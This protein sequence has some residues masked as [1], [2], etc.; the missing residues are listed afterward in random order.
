MTRFMAVA[1]ML[2]AQC[3]TTVQA[4]CHKTENGICD[5]HG[6]CDE[7]GICNCYD[8]HQGADCSQ[9]SCP[10]GRS[11]FDTPI[12]Q[13]NTAHKRSECSGQGH[14]DRATGLCKCKAG[15]NGM[16]CERQDCPNNCNNHGTCIS[17]A[18][19]GT[20]YDAFKF[21]RTAFYNDWDAELNY[22]CACDFQWEGYDCSQRRLPRGSN[23]LVRSG[24]TEVAT[25]YCHCP[26]PCNGTFVLQFRGF[27]SKPLS[28]QMNA[29]QL[30]SAFTDLASVSSN[31]AIYEK[32]P[33]A[34]NFTGAG[35]S[36]SDR[37]CSPKGT[38]TTFTFNEMLG[39]QY[40]IYLTHS[41]DTA[42]NFAPGQWVNNVTMH[43]ET[44][45][46]IWCTCGANCGGTFSIGY[47][48]IYTTELPWNSTNVTIRHALIGLENLAVDEVHVKNG[49][50]FPYGPGL[51]ND[52]ICA[53]DQTNRSMEITFKS[54]TGN[55]PIIDLVP[56]LLSN[57]MKAGKMDVTT[58]DGTGAWEI[59]NGHGIADMATATCAC[60]AG[61]HS[62]KLGTCNRPLFNTSAYTGMQRCPGTV[63]QTNIAIQYPLSGVVNRHLY[64]T[65]A[66]VNDSYA[67]KAL[68]VQKSHI[69]KGSNRTYHT[70]GA[71]RMDIDAATPYIAVQMKN[72]SNSSAAGCALDL[73]ARRFYYIDHEIKGIKFMSIDNITNVSTFVSGVSATLE[74][75]TLDLRAGRRHVYV[76][77]PGKIGTKD[78]DLLRYN[79]D[80]MLN[81][82]NYT[83]TIGQRYLQDPTGIALDLREEHIYWVDTGNSSKRDGKMYRTNLDGTGITLIC[84][85]FTDPRGIALDLTNSTAFVTDTG[86]YGMRRPA[87]VKLSMNYHLGGNYS[88]FQ[89]IVTKHTYAEETKTGTY[90]LTYPYG[91]AL[92]PAS[93]MIFWTDQAHGTVSTATYEGKEPLV[94]NWPGPKSAPRGIA[95][96]NGGTY[97]KTYYDCYGHGYCAGLETD[98]KCECD[99]GYFGNCQMLE[100][101]TGPAW[102]DEAIMNND[103]HNEA[104][105]SNMGTCEYKT[106]TCAC[107]DGFEGAACERMSCPTDEL[108]NVCS[109]HGQCLSMA[110][111]AKLTRTNGV[112]TP[113][114]YGGFNMSN[115]TAWDAD[116]VFGCVCD[117]KGYQLPGQ[118]ANL[119]DWTGYDCSR[120]TC[121]SG[122]KRSNVGPGQNNAYNSSFEI[123]NMTC[124]ATSGTFTLSFRSESTEP[125][126]SNATKAILKQRLEELSTIGQVVITM[127]N[128]D[129]SAYRFDSVCSASAVTPIYVG[130]KFIS[131]LGNLPM[132]TA[133]DAGLVGSVSIWE[134]VPGTK[135]E[136]ECANNGLCNDQTGFCDCFTGYTTSN[137]DGSYGYRGDCGFAE[138]P[139]PG[140]VYVPALGYFD[141]NYADDD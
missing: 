31:A 127:D 9:R 88:Y 16:G 93:S 35:G 141:P 108:G 55:L 48:G 70:H 29:G 98:F 43:M 54:H 8:G 15:F 126:A 121:P 76:T 25:M 74:G 49:V 5:G 50:D 85:N 125:I 124:T 114:S 102:F 129:A 119:S 73:S 72:M 22:G 10:L 41:L 135:V 136:F 46:R 61:F 139:S 101:P 30:Q 38:Y 113:I 130:V 39:D 56:S 34:V 106:G 23:Y 52:G 97:P 18:T 90:Y 4:Q 17:M 40:P 116:K 110:D 104:E 95:F 133:N 94:I 122:T 87:I 1:V 14:C 63:Y 21:N 123:Q 80:G 137:A 75:L 117:S 91:I 99:D 109:G 138:I 134:T 131:E 107:N 59:C 71:Y 37:V 3:V 57:G 26:N 45:Q 32:Y 67:A 103:A 83:N 60:D 132:L 28:P 36:Y 58:D 33:V 120:R 111:A 42:M 112:L 115:A 12:A 69:S 89:T 53:N 128:Q 7:F 6:G 44:K 62:D 92:D 84:S 19:A 2:L 81:M 68:Y 100:C 65:D 82:K 20:R 47:D 105:C 140:G 51:G 64:F 24:K 27:R 96:D 118:L 79:L 78:G 11:W 13:N 86:T 77:D 66:G